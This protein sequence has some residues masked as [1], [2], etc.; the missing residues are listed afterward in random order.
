MT[1]IIEAL[2]KTKDLRRKADEIIDKIAKHSADLDCETPAYPDQKRQVAEWLQS[3]SDIIKEIL[4]LNYS[5]QRTNIKTMVTIELGGKLVTK[6][7][8]EWILRR[9]ELAGLEEKAWRQLTDRNL[10]DSQYQLTPGSPQAVVKKR[11]YYDPVERD[12][13][14]ELY[15]S[16]PHKI[17]STLEI[18]NATTDIIDL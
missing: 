7:I 6:S 12:H 2:K 16:E 4:A 3:H 1:K 5:I 14:V 10:K 17:D 8:F 18:I 9:R 15:R 11:L 13:K